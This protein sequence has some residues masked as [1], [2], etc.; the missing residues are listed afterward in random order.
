VSTDNALSFLKRYTV[1]DGNRTV[2]LVDEV[3]YL[4]TKKQ[5]VL[6]E[7]FSLP[8]LLKSTLVLLVVTNTL[9]LHERVMKSSTTSRLVRCGCCCVGKVWA[10]LC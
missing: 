6:Y 5:K 9:D 2:L 7:L 10:F 4:Y 8:G 3:D 1:S